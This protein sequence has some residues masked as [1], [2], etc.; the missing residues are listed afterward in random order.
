MKSVFGRYL[1]GDSFLYKVDARVKILLTIV[2]IVLM[3]FV[4]SLIS[5]IVLLIPLIVAY[6]LTIKRIMPLFKIL[7]FP[8]IISVIIFL[9][10]IYSINYDFNANAQE[11]S[12]V[13]DGIIL[14]LPIWKA[15]NIAL[16][17]NA[18]NK[19]ITLFI[20]IYT[21]ILCTTILTNTTKPILLTKAIEDLLFPLKLIKVPVHIIA[22]IISIAL[23]FIPT[24][25]DEATRIMKAQS[26][27][28]VDFKS[29]SI[30]EK[31]TAFT[32][33]II[34]L[35]V[36]SFAK[37]EDLSNALETRGYD[38][39]QKRT[40]YRQ[41]HFGW[42]DVIIILIVAILTAFVI[43]EIYYLLPFVY[44]EQFKLWM[45]VY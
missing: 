7:K 18:L 31:V 29:G 6:V 44:P 13:N 40:R 38:P 9:V 35:F 43:T 20:R 30:K 11:S 4:G 15:K 39:Y 2:Y 36:S 12:K 1:P 45:R 33:L 34:P 3:F 23:R 25:L 26:S 28:G 14:L 10:S 37:A 19:T 17:Y 32:T 22:M 24:L 42:R 21:M 5:A 16:T 27:R 41:L 8:L